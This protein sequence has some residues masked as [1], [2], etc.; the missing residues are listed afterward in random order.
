MKKLTFVLGIIL[1][2]FF[3]TTAQAQ[4]D[5]PFAR[6]PAI[7]PDGSTIAFSYQGD[8]WSV[9]AEGG[10]AWRMTVHEGYDA[11][12]KWSPD[13]NK[14]AFVSN[15]HGNDDVFV[16]NKNGS[17]VKQLTHHSTDDQL[18][19]WTPE[20]SVMFTTNR[21]FNQV[22]WEPEIHTVNAE[23]GT[24]DRFF[25][26]FGMMATMSPDGRY[27]VY[28]RGSNGEFRK[29]YRGPANKDLWVYGIENDTY[30]QLTDFNGNDM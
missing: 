8:I 7:S 26:S 9:P 24:P 3:T 12:P 4:S 17:Q 16:M 23:G 22:E 19:A 10:R 5:E 1:W 27:L 18:T 13:G 30:N 29:G 6:F 14:I 15:R 28:V 20:N 25:D 11:R 21:V 2:T